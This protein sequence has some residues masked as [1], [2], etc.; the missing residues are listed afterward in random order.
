[1]LGLAWASV[2]P[3]YSALL[4]LAAGLGPWPRSAGV[5][6][7]TILNAVALGLFAR[8]TLSWFFKP[9]G[10]AE[11][12]LEMPP[13]ASRQFRGA[14]RLL[15]LAGMVLLAPAHLFLY[16]EISHDGPAF[17]ASALARFLI[18]GFEMLV[19][20]SLVY[21]LRANSALMLWIN[22]DVSIDP[23]G[24][25]AAQPGSPVISI[26]RSPLGAVDSA[27][28][29]WICRRARTIG[30]LIVAYCAIVILFDFNGYT[31]AARR[32][33]LGGVES[34]AVFMV[35][36]GVHRVLGRVIA[37]RARSGLLSRRIWSWSGAATLISQRPHRG[38]ADSASLDEEAEWALRLSRVLTFTVVATGTA[39]LG[40]V[41]GI[42]FSLLRFLSQ[43]ELWT[44]ADGSPEGL[45]V[46][47]G[48]VVQGASALLAG[49]V[50]WRYMAALL[51]ITVFRK[52][53][54]DPGARFA[55][56]TLCR[57]A[58]LGLAAIV[59]LESI[60][61]GLAQ[62]SVILAALGVGL[63]FGLQEIVSNFVSGI[64]LLLERPIRVG[65]VVT[66]A[67]MSGKVERINIRATT[68]INADNQSLIVPNREFITANLVNWTHKDR[69]LRVN[70]PLTVAYGADPDGVSDLLLSIARN[71]VDVLRN[72]VPAASMEGFGEFGMTFSL[73][74]HVPDPSVAG[75]VKHRLCA[76]IQAR[77][78]AAG[79]AIPMPIH[80]VVLRSPARPSAEAP[81]IAWP[82]GLRVDPSAAAPPSPKHAS[83]PARAP[84]PAEPS[85]RGV[86]E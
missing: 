54:D 72:P 4:A 23:P 76:E 49:G 32:L 60:H 3:C 52:M 74:V 19:L 46:V 65:D 61:L 83:G 2:W 64:I 77:F 7:A 58:A 43:H 10:W 47:V 79:I 67:G 40:W 20:A 59:A 16:G 38:G 55:V 82:G 14:G 45:P 35:A 41:W 53:P 11:R 42:D 8:G 78:Q 5:L 13:S 71:D 56:V 27:W 73:H 6:A 80:E 75:R 18:L 85:H 29:T 66:V 1:L 24:P 57:Y 68:I 51:A 9:E 33:T 39:A 44:V 34:L 12:Y 31:F 69:V 62:I 21:H 81:V 28:A 84:E 25:P 63:G 26:A 70:I 36:W 15:T 30:R 17:T 86:D 22:P 48:D 50:L 37:W